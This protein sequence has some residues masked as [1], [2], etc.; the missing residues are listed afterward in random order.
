MIPP[1]LILRD[2]AL[3]GLVLSAGAW[4]WGGEVA[5]AVTAGAVA[6][7]A[8]FWLL[9]VAARGAVKGGGSAALLPMKLL[10]ACGLASVLVT[11]FPPIPALIGFATGPLGIVLGGLHGAHLLQSAESR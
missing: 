1:T 9:I 11:V 3:V 8:N 2:T 4:L 7:V 6:A 5:V 10:L